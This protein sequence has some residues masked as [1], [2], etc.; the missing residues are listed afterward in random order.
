MFLTAVALLLSGALAYTLTDNSTVRLLVQLCCFLFA[1]TGLY[2]AIRRFRTDIYARFMVIL[3]SF[4]VLMGCLYVLHSRFDSSTF[5]HFSI[6]T[7]RLVSAIEIICISFA[8]IVKMRSLQQENEQYRAELDKYL[9]ALEVKEFSKDQLAEELKQQYDL[10]DR[11]V[12]VLGCLWDGL[13]NQ[14]ISDRLYIT[15]S[16]AK[17]HVSN[18]YTKL[19][20]KNRNQVQVLG[21]ALLAPSNP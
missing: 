16:T 7:F 3:F 13:T 18:L 19:D 14:E 5:S 2:L 4:V 8:I 20:V 1:I 6:S 17:F 12:E 15:V 10:T 11:E 21:T 9:K